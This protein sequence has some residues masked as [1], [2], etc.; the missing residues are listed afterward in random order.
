MLFL[1][2]VDLGLKVLH[3]RRQLV[4]RAARSA[5]VGSVIGEDMDG[6]GD[7]GAVVVGAGAW[8]AGGGRGAPGS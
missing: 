6:L 5:V 3:S 1:E 2:R 4:M 7:G 8:L